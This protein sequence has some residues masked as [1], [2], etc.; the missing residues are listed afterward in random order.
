MLILSLS[1]KLPGQFI[2]SLPRNG[3][4]RRHCQVVWQAAKHVG[5]RFTGSAPA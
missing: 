5:V 2:L 3:E 4:V 1:D